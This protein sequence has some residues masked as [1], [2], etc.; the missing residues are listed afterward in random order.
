MLEMSEVTDER[1][2][3]ARH[4]CVRYG[5][6]A[7]EEARTSEADDTP[8]GG[9][10]SNAVPF[11]AVSGGVPGAEKPRRIGGDAGLDCKKGREVY[12]VASRGR[13]EESRGAEE[14]EEEGHNEVGSCHWK[15]RLRIVR[16]KAVFVS[17]L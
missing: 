1:G 12:R 17:V 3:C 5:V 16:D 13:D 7:R 6:R 14:E 8:L 11:A 2:D 15:R 4:G 10:T 9:I